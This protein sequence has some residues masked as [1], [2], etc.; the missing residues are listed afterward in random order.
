MTSASDRFVR[1]QDLV[2]Q[3]RLTSLTA[4]VIGVG[5]IGRQVALQLAAIGVRRIELLDFD[6]VDATNVTTQG[7]R[8]AD[9]G[10]AKVA[11]AADALRELDQSV[12]VAQV[13]SRW[14][15]QVA[16]GDAVF[17]CVDSITARAAIWRSARAS[18]RFWCDVH[19]RWTW[20]PARMGWDV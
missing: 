9:I 17:C 10:R 20:S 19:P 7:Y 18:C 16:L 12:D 8:V 11:A 13:C 6:E 5:A 2:P 4:T 14:R 15:P 3:R 1:Q